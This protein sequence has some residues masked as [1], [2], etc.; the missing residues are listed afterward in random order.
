MGP[1]R[2]RCPDGRNRRS[3]GIPARLDLSRC[4]AAGGRCRSWSPAAPRS[5]VSRRPGRCATAAAFHLHQVDRI[6]GTGA[7]I[8]RAGA[9]PGCRRPV[10]V[11]VTLRTASMARC[12]RRADRRQAPQIVGHQCGRTGRRCGV[13]LGQH[14][15]DEVERRS[16]KGPVAVHPAAARQPW[17]RAKVSPMAPS[18]PSHDAS[19]SRVWVRRTPRDRPQRFDAG[20]PPGR[21][22]GRLTMSGAHARARASR[23]GR[24]DEAR[25]VVDQAAIGHPRA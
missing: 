8:D 1:I 23:R 17:P 6:D 16:E 12:R 21:R 25:V 11:T 19:S 5:S 2:S 10:L 7:D 9:A 14:H 15:L 13:G 4:C 22:D 24:L 18:T 20:P 3:S